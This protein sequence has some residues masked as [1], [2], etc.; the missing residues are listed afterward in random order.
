MLNNSAIGPSDLEMDLEHCLLFLMSCRF[1]ARIAIKVNKFAI[2]KYVIGCFKYEKNGEYCIM[3]SV[4]R[5]NFP[6]TLPGSSCC[7]I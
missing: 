4:L 3:S 2:L 6:E 7:T 1:Y 5:L